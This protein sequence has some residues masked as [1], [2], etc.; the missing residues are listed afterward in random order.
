ME[1][2]PLTKKRKK[3]WHKQK[4]CHTYKK[5]VMIKITVRFEISYYTG[6]YS[7]AAQSICTLRYKIPKEIPLVLQ[8]G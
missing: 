4:L 1:T 5:N 2:L 7:G 3:S 8:N 6:K